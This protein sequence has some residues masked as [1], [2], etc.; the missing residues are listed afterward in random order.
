[1]VRVA[2]VAI[3]ATLGSSVTAAPAHSVAFW[4]QIADNK[5]AVP[6]GS[7]LPELTAELTEML[8][9]PDP[10]LR[11]DIAYSTLAAWIYQTRVLEGETLGTLVTSLLGNLIA[12]IGETGTDRIFRRSFS[13]LT[14]GAVIARDNAASVL[15][16][17]EFHRIERAAFAYLRDE[18]DLRGYDPERG[19]MHSAAHTADLLKFIGRSRFLAADGQTR[20]LDAIREKLQNAPT[21]FT[22]GE[23][24]RFARAVLSIVNRTDFDAAAF[25]EW[26]AR[27]KPA[28]L[29][30]KPTVADL[31]RLQNSKNLLAKLDV[32]LDGIAQPSEAVRSAHE[33]VRAAVKDAF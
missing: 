31:S 18:R 27:M 5:Y 15:T 8:A 22:H 24:E 6:A 3:L 30:E 23:D 21:V 33:S 29:G 26:A 1:M 20:L 19:W 28:R 10:E 7:N 2:L 12:G 25:T 14:L 32:L 16:E 9:S 13:A 11:D 4:K 17:V